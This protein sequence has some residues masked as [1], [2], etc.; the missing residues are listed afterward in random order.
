[1]VICS[2][3]GIVRYCIENSAQIAFLTS[4]II[5]DLLKGIVGLAFHIHAAGC[6]I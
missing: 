2:Y 4:V 3:E 1:M 5:C 6:V